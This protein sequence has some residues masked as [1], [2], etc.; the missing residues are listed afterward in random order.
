MKTTTVKLA[1]EGWTLVTNKQAL[2]QFN[3]RVFMALTGGPAP[4]EN[5]G[6]VMEA[7]EKYINNSNEVS[8]YVRRIKGGTG[9]ESVR[10]AEVTA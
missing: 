2:L 10:V 6:F 9:V 8:V 5:I 4:D 3:D 7:R 1:E